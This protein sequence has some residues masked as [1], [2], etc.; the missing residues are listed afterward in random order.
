MVYI[1]DSMYYM[2]IKEA[3]SVIFK[4]NQTAKMK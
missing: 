2:K 4:C 1:M 3:P